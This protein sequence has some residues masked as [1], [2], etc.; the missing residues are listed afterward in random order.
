MNDHH[1]S[2]GPAPEASTYFRDVPATPIAAH[3]DAPLL[4]RGS[5]AWCLR[6]DR[7]QEHN[8]LDPADIDAISALLASMIGPD[9]TTGAVRS[10][11]ITGTGERTFS[12]GY[13]LDAI[14]TELDDRFERM[15]DA[16]ETLPCVTVAALNGSVYGGATD[17]ALC[18]DVR[19]G[20]RPSRMFMPAAQF[21]LHYYPG[22]LRR[23][24]ARLGLPAASRLML[25]GITIETDE[26]LRIGFL[27]DAVA[28]NALWPS[29]DTQLDAISKTEP[30]AVA[31][32]KQH[33]HRI[34][35]DG[36]VGEQAALEASM[37]A[38]YTDSLRSEALHARL[39]ARLRK[40]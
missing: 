13:T 17:L 27:A 11:V 28:A 33:L 20:V 12:S 8:R 34:A 40:A 22:G 16:L 39:K 1:A 2:K 23:Y 18:C 6:L 5:Q 10:L 15:L 3:A 26:M 25:T 24:V 38:A 30:V 29:V 9:G 14:A 19:I 37:R 7:P 36:S 31:K 4:Y 21:G 32:M 35:R